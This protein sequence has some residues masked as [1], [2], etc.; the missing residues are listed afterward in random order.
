LDR[1]PVSISSAAATDRSTDR[2]TNRT[3]LQVFL[4]SVVVQSA[5]THPVRAAKDLAPGD[6]R[7]FR[8]RKAKWSAQQPAEVF[9]REVAVCASGRVRLM[10]VSLPVAILYKAATFPIR[11]QS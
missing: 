8:L 10:T 9:A 6:L 11:E 7:L 2:R 4:R 1:D 5:R 3:T